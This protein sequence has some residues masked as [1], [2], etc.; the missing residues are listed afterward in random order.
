MS[1][2]IE[3]STDLPVTAQEVFT[4]WLDSQAHSQFTGST[5]VI[6]PAAGGSFTAWD[7]YIWGT[8]LEIEQYTRILQA[9]RTV[10][11]PEASPD[12]LLEIRF[13]DQL[14]GMRL[15]LLPTQ[16]PDGQGQEYAQGW[17]DSY[18]TPM[19]AYFTRQADI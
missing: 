11:F 3:V 5:A 16:R 4:A 7:G 14:G 17:Q 12:S 10:D 2:Q 9:W 8:T 6:D 18:F 15:D 19:L 13:T 1:E